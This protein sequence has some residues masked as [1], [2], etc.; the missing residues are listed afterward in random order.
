V[1]VFLDT[2]A[3]YALLVSNDESHDAVRAA[4]A[5]L[6]TDRR[7]LWTT[8]FVIVETLALLQH[9]IGLD[10][11][12]DF[13][14]EVLPAVRVRWVDEHL[15]RLGIDR[16]WRED[17]RQVSLVDCVSFEFMRMERVGAALAVDTHFADAGFDVLPRAR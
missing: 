8:S 14:E 4:F 15:Y 3:F 1:S 17:R 10:A 2:S 16:L 11:A 6:I 9:R 13:D 12:R 5:S 7:L